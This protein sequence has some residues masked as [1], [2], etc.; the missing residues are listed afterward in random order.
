MGGGNIMIE[1]AMRGSTAGLLVLAL[2]LLACGGE[3][4]PDAALE[5]A[6][7]T[8]K[9][10][11]AEKDWHTIV[12][13]TPPSSIIGEE[14]AYLEAVNGPTAMFLASMVDT[15][16]EKLRTM[17]FREYSAAV[18][19]RSME[20]SITRRSDL[21]YARIVD[22]RIEGDQATIRAKSVDIILEYKFVKEDGRWYWKD[23]AD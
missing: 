12:G 3:S 10:A 19:G 23:L 18:F 6:F 11:F 16:V 21:M 15:D 8:I 1:L 7:Y 22:T 5:D 4:S 2:V 20:W 9:E 14:E 17:A 13:F